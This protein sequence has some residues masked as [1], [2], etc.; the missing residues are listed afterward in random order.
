MTHLGNDVGTDAC[1]IRP[2]PRARQLVLDAG[3]NAKR[4]HMMHGLLEVDV[5][6]P[7]QRLR[8]IE[9]S[10][11]E[12]LSFTAFIAACLGQAIEADRSVH[13]YRDWLGRLVIFDEADA[14]LGIES[15]S[16]G[17]RR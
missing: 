11:G 7:R 17:A 4:R 10:S 2:F 3:W 8:Q 12:R 9:A 13:A 14:T 6:A 5:T 15:R 16:T 1:E